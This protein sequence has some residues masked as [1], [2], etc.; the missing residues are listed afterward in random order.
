MHRWHSFV[1]SDPDHPMLPP[2][3]SLLYLADPA[4]MLFP[5]PPQLPASTNTDITSS[6]SAPVGEEWNPSSSPSLP[7]SSI[8]DVTSKPNAQLTQLAG[9]GIPQGR[10]PASAHEAVMELMDNPHPL[11]TLA[12]PN[13]YLSSGTISRY[14]NPDNYTSVSPACIFESCK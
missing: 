6:S 4:E 14:H 2:G 3:P 7:P 5:P 10:I 12:D 13:A 1:G 8:F 9:K 11:E